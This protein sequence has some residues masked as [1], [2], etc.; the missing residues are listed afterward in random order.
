M[1]L[2]VNACVRKQSRTKRLAEILL[3]RLSGEVEEVRLSELSFPLVDEAFLQERDRLI[4]AGDFDDPLFDLARQFARADQIVIAAPYWDL[5][6]PA[7]F[8]QYIEQINALGVTF[9][10]T[11][12]GY[13]QGLCRASKLYYVTTAG[14]MFVPEEYGFGYVKALAQE[15][16]GIR[17]VELIQAVGLDIDGADAEGIMQQVIRSIRPETHEG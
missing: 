14:G 10:Y 1:V 12:D 6:F 5:S 17:D 9:K 16:Y 2:F 4:A 13:P 11:P 8:K 15:F 3:T 7:A